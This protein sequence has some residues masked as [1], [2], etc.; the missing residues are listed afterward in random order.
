MP[1]FFSLKPL[2]G[3]RISTI[4]ALG[5]SVAA[6]GAI[7]ATKSSSSE[8]VS[9]LP[10][11]AI[12]SVVVRNVGGA[13]CREAPV[14]F[15]QPFRRGDLP[16]GETIVGYLG[17][18]ALPTQINIKA[19][20]PDGSVR[21]GIITM[22][23]P[24]QDLNGRA[25]ISLT[26]K[27]QSRTP[28][29]GALSIQELLRTR[30]NASLSLNIAGNYWSIEARPLL[31]EALAR[32]G[33]NKAGVLCRPWL[34]G[35]LASEWVVGGPL[36]SDKGI[37]NPHLA[38]YFAVR[39]YGPPPIRRV[40]VDVIVENDWAYQPD[41]HNYHYDATIDIGRKSVFTINQLTHYR[42]ARWHKVF[43]W[44]SRD[45]L[46]VAL[47]SDYLQASG[48][49][50]Q[51]E[52]VRPSERL[53]SRVLQKCPPMKSCNVTPHMGNTGAQAD[54]GP[55]PRWS[56]VYVED[57]N[58][59]RAFRWML[60]NADALG[61]YDIHLREK[62]TG[63]PVSVERHPCLTTIGPAQLRRCPVP[64]HANDTLPPCKNDCKSPFVPD[65]SHHPAPAYV[66]YLVT[67]DWYYMEELEFWADWVEFWQNPAYRGY[68]KGLIHRTQVRGQAWAL[69]TLGDAAY[70]LPDDSPLKTWFNQV[71]ENNIRW[72]N[73]HY[74]DNPGANRLHI[75]TG[76]HAIIYPSH[77]HPRT[78]IAT[79][80]QS[81]FDW[82]LGNLVDQG[83]AGAKRLRNWFAK[84][85]VGLMTS[86]EFC[87]ELAS[88]YELRVRNTRKSPL[89]KSLAEVYSKTFPRLKGVSCQSGPI[90]AALRK[91]RPHHRF[92]YPPNSMVG[93]PRSPTGFPANF[94]IGLAE[95]VDSGLPG[96]RK[97]WLIFSR[98]AS[99]PNYGNSPQFAVIPRNLDGAKNHK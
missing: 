9:S 34:K 75:L 10:S 90:N 98:R 78:G 77:G 61:S 6:C 97:A 52:K 36:R 39:A 58:S 86:P 4:I 68:R 32:G 31:E 79:W 28:V 50:P 51:Y 74:T 25:R 92:F 22:L 70:I 57:P 89:Y 41:P 42:D 2:N 67:G 80:Q 44:G 8:S 47:N 87:W 60:A 83:F 56:S 1:S 33:C 5:F 71:V 16:D 73:H 96:S 24:C 81:F 26:K 91:T 27:K 48:A 15:G 30:F 38:A 88:A 65:E 37:P 18:R 43:W 93:Y 17:H 55:L 69:R 64:P 53:L 23:I 46:Y 35:A 84:F 12:T 40:R 95:S 85:Q 45:T 13:A 14:T 99:Q 72:Y 76:Y 29:N 21:H 94:Q 66:A 19:R 54:I 3:L 63:E 7:G 20:N 82:A 59:Y 11:G 62:A 49:V